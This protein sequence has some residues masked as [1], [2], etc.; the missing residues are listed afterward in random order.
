MNTFL[1]GTTYHMGPL[2]DD[3]P[4]TQF[5]WGLFAYTPFILILAVF[6][7]IPLLFLV[8]A[9]LEAIRNDWRA[10]NSA[11]KCCLLGSLFV[12]AIYVISHFH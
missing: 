8:A 9:I 2:G 10:P 11:I 7:G 3:N 5:I 6:V 1:L 4:I 12:I